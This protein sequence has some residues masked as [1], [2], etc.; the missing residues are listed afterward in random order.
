MQKVQN[1]T[2]YIS[3]VPLLQLVKQCYYNYEVYKLCYSSA[4]CVMLYS[5]MEFF[6]LVFKFLF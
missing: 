3:M 1:F 2:F 5:Y 6:V 4:F